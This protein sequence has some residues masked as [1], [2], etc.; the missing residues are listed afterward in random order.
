MSLWFVRNVIRQ[1]QRIAGKYGDDVG[2]EL[3]F[4]PGESLE[5]YFRKDAT[6]VLN[7]PTVNLN[8]KQERILELQC[9]GTPM[10]YIID[11]AGT[12]QKIQFGWTGY[13]DADLGKKPWLIRS[14]SECVDRLENRLPPAGGAD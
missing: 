5:R 1:T 7:I 9:T 6:P 8:R 4:T 11:R 14:A 13:A 2:V 10:M 12:I 3:D